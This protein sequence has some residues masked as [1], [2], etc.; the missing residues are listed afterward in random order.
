M[1]DREDGTHTPPSQ[2][3]RIRLAI[4]AVVVLASLL[5]IS[6]WFKN[7]TC[8]CGSR[9]LPWETIAVAAAGIAI[10][11][12]AAYVFVAAFARRQTD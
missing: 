12:S 9:G 5:A 4:A 11:S 10:V 6:A 7:A 1:T 3:A 2:P 8:G